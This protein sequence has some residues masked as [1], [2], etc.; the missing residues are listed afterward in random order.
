VSF[1]LERRR[2]SSGNEKRV[3]S[4]FDVSFAQLTFIDLITIDLMTRASLR[5][6][7]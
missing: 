3:R 5:R 7:H 2:Q 1:E 4:G 6:G